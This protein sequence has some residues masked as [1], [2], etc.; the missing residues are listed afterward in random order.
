MKPVVLLVEDN[1]ETRDMYRVALCRS[2]YGVREAADGEEGVRLA[3]LH[4]PALVVM[5]VALPVLDGWSATVRLKSDPETAA[6]PVIILSG[7]TA[8]DDHERSSS[9]GC[10]AYL[11]K[12]LEPSRLV[13]AVRKWIPLETG[14]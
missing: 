5:N 8:P 3:R 14:R 6:I 9:S 12:P 2:G 1:E 13:E 7:L 10:D 4:R 11:D